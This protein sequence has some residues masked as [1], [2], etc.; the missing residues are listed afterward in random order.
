MPFEGL[1]SC[2]MPCSS[3]CLQSGFVIYERLDMLLSK[4]FFY[5]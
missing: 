4:R 3:I 1:L 2:F 5:R